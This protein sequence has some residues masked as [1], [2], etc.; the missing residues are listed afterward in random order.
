VLERQLAVVEHG[1][2]RIEDAAREQP[3]QHPLAGVVDQAD[4]G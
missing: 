1:Q 2:H 4:R 3:D